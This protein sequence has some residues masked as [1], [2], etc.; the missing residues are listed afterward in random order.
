MNI[1]VL[2]GAGKMGSIATQDLA[3]DPR[4]SRVIIADRDLDQARIVAE[5]IDSPKIELRQA[6][7]T[8]HDQLVA[9]LREA[10]A[11]LNATVYY[12]NL[13]VMEACLAAGTHY[14]DM[15]GLFH[16][17]RKQL[18]LNSRFADAGISAVLGMGSAPGVP[19]VQARY[20]VDRLDTIETIR[21]Y[22]GI[23]PPPPDDVRFTYA[24]PTIVDELT[25]S[26]MVYR[27]GEFVACEP[28]SE[29]ED[30]WFTPP[31]G[32]LPMHLSLHSEVATLPLTFGDRG[33]QECTFKINY[34]GMAKETVEKIRVLADFG[35][36]GREP[37]AVDG[38]SVV[39]RDLLVAMM[40]D[41]V[42]PITDFLAP[43]QTEPPD[44]TKEIVTEVRGTKDGKAVTYRLGTLTC[45]GA[46]PTGVA[47]ARAAIWMAEGRIPPGVHPPEAAIEPEPF[48]REL[49]TREIYTQVSVSKFL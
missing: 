47:P 38:Q 36:A 21:I 23:K 42:P 26:P 16:T 24:V 32:L 19:N 10:D 20:A 45:K 9:L 2:G 12:F 30:Y 11:C 49:E 17:T 22:D 8:D 18:E 39:P 31:L 33:L 4:V 29:F 1:V 6:D 34:W 15:G 14:T 41:Y 46:L 35:F 25:L 48:F 40:A 44:W 13:Q 37:V 27:D 3:Q 7:A 5:T 28:L 43:P